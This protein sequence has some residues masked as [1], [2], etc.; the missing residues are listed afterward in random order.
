[1]AAERVAQ[2][3]ESFA[4]RVVQET[5]LP[6]PAQQR[7]ELRRE[8]LELAEDRHRRETAF[9]FQ[10]A[11]QALHERAINRTGAA[12]RPLDLGHRGAKQLHRSVPIVGGPYGVES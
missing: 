3:S 7:A 11:Q 4:A 9:L 2:R 5:V 12:I 10:I 8:R 1:M 6:D